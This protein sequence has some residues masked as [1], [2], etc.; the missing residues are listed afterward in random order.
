MLIR[1]NANPRIHD[2][3]CD[4]IAGTIQ[5]F[6]L[7]IPAT[8][9]RF[10]RQRDFAFVGELERVREQILQYLLQ[11]FG[12]GKHR[13]WQP[14]IEA[15]E[16]VHVLRFGDMAEGALDIAAQ[17]VEVKVGGVDCHRAGLD[18]GQIENVVDQRQQIVARRVNRLGEL[19][20]L[21]RQI[22]AL[23]LT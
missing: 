14:W 13:L 16:E 19:D 17:I 5:A 11:P 15:D 10:D 18:L 3:E 12:V 23:V 20:L 9:C 22:A 8:G 2:G 4:H 6:V 7:R 1:R 21:D